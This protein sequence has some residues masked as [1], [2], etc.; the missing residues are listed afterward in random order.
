MIFDPKFFIKEGRINNRYERQLS[1]LK[2]KDFSTIRF[3][4]TI[5]K[6]I[7]NLHNDI[8][9]FVIYGDPQSGKTEMM[10]VLAAK[11]LDEGNKIIIILLN[12][13]VNLLNQNSRRFTSVG[14]NPTPKVL[15]EVISPDVEIGNKTWIIFCKKNS[16]DLQKLIKK[17]GPVESKI[18]IDD[19]GDYATPN[20]KI[21]E[22][23]QTKINQLVGLLLGNGIYIGVTATPARLDL[24]NTFNNA[25][26]NWIYL[27]PHEKYTGQDIFFPI[28]KKINFRL[29]YLPEEY[30]DPRYLRTALISFLIN[31]AYLNV[32]KKREGPYCMLIHTSGIRAD[33][34]EDYKQVINIMSILENKKDKKILDYYRTIYELAIKRFGNEDLANSITMFIRDNIGQNKVVVMNSNTDKKNVDYTIITNPQ[35][36]F[37]IAIG[38]NIV[39]RGVTFKNLLSMFFTRDVKHKIQ[40]DTYIQ[41]ARMFGSRGDYLSFFELTIPERL[42]ADWHRCF[43][44]HRLSLQSAISGDA[45]VWI[46]DSRV[47]SVSASSIDK[48]TVAMNNGEMSFEIFNYSYEIEK[49]I[50]N[51]K[52]PFEII[53]KL[54]K[55]F[56]DDCLPRFLI[57]FIDRFSYEGINS[58]AVHNSTD[59]SNRGKD[60]DKEIIQRAR[61]F[62][63]HSEME[64]N[65]YP[66]ATHHIKI[67]FNSQNNKA[68]VFYRYVDS[69]KFLKNLKNS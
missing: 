56:G 50:N 55:L 54:N 4:D 27:K 38:G 39:S 46:E 2:G 43:I 69:V 6:A 41:R 63:G 18:I 13:D 60:V 51:L 30:D 9:S 62:I 7:N 47:R 53:N 61:G 5:N 26:K 40:Q 19:E 36:L 11:L 12:D 66:H 21:N 65:K 44:F 14:L 3:E 58:L 49:S 37:T 48:T 42:Y 45:P 68:R 15:D 17:I 23:E 29:H 32:S 57:D 34:T 31:V 20:S 59:I 52:N 67:F 1:R 35:A 10:I 33:H 22:R 25:S 8:K 24:N 64:T 16:K 28:G